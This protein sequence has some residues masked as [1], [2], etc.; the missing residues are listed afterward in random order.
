VLGSPEETTL[1][2]FSMTSFSVMVE[3]RRSTTTLGVPVP[4]RAAAASATAGRAAIG[5]GLE[6][7]SEEAPGY[8]GRL[9]EV[10]VLAGGP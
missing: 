4:F 9:G 8:L 3:I 6:T 5:G 1:L 2:S 7:A 10:L